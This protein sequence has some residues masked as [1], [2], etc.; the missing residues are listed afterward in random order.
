MSNTR[1]LLADVG[2]VNR[3]TAVVAILATLL[4]AYAGPAPDG[5]ALAAAAARVRREVPGPFEPEWPG[6]HGAGGLAEFR[7][8]FPASDSPVSSVEK[9]QQER[10]DRDVRQA[11]EAL[12]ALSGGGVR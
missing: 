1:D 5:A 7:R 6:T 11:R 10:T 12:L 4:D 8:R 3:D 9:V 2:L